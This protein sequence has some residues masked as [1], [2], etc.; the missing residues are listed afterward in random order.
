MFNE[1]SKE[2]MRYDSIQNEWNICSLWGQPLPDFDNT[3]A[4]EFY[5]GDDRVPCDIPHPLF[6]VMA[7]ALE[8]ENPIVH[9][10]SGD[11]STILEH[12]ETEVLNDL[13]L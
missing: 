8:D 9:G 12:F 7:H 6:E 10:L 1:Y 4:A 3:T 2:Q 5:P 11:D 13:S